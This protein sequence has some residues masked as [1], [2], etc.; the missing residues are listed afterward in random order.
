MLRHMCFDWPLEMFYK[1]EKGFEIVPLPSWVNNKIWAQ[2]C[3]H[4]L[5]QV[6]CDHHYHSTITLFDSLMLL[7]VVLVKLFCFAE[8]KSARSVSRSESRESTAS[9][10][11]IELCSQT[12]SIASSDENATRIQGLQQSG[13]GLIQLCCR[14][15]TYAYLQV[16]FFD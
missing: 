11:H 3:D 10:P 5:I 6:F 4:T 16:L 8:F 13:S 7:I 15:C 2:E 9:R 1:K 12:Q 14:F